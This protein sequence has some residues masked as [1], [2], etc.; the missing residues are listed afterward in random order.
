MVIEL[1]GVTCIL[2]EA[3]PCRRVRFLRVKISDVAAFARNQE[4]S[5]LVSFY[6]QIRCSQFLVGD[7][8]I[9]RFS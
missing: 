8:P 7:Y 5:R 6:L 4:G 1:Y 2:Y 9:V 3:S